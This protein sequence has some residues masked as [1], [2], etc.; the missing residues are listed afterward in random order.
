MLGEALIVLGL[1]YL[2]LRVFRRPVLANGTRVHLF[3]DSLAQG[4]GSPLKAAL[5]AKGVTL[6]LDAV[7]GTTAPA[8][9]TRGPDGTFAAGA[10]VALISLG[11]ND[12]TGNE[13]TQQRFIERAQDI[14]VSLRASG[15]RP[16]WLMPPSMPFSLDLIALGLDNTGDIVVDPPP[17][18]ERYD[19]VHPAKPADWQRWADEIVRQLT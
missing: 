5:A 14:S 3:G 16:V 10:S 18:L 12:A 9:V 7:P 17:N 11:T 19:R 4:L 6:T 2:G 8:W 13:T 1:A 15:V